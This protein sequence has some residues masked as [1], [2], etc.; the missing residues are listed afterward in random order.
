[1]MCATKRVGPAWIWS[2]V[3]CV[4]AVTAAVLGPGV[5]ACPRALI[6]S[7]TPLGGSVLQLPDIASTRELAVTDPNT[8]VLVTLMGGGNIFSHR[9]R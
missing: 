4:V 3:A 2:R 5:D 8:G 9:V 6:F 7:T 1:M